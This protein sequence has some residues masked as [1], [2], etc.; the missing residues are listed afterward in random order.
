MNV[1]SACPRA[2]TALLAIAAATCAAL[3]A[4][5]EPAVSQPATFFANAPESYLW[6]SIPSGATTVHWD[7]PETAQSATVT[8]EG[9][10]YSSVQS[11]LTGESCVLSIPRASASKEDVFKVTLAFDDGSTPQVAYLGAETGLGTSG[12]ATA[13]KVKLETASNWGT[14]QDYAAI[15][16]LPG[17]TSLTVN[18]EPLPDLDGNAGWRLLRY[19]RVSQYAIAMNGNGAEYPLQASVT[20]FAGGTFMILN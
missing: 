2:P 9:A 7:M 17:A 10:N 15:A 14:F 19:R 8:I 13:S 5:A 20:G 11:G 12:R 1:K 3:W 16:V 18:G 6:H 4:A